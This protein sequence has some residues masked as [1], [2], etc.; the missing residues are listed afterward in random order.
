MQVGGALGPGAAHLITGMMQRGRGRGP[1]WARVGRTGRP[2][3]EGWPLECPGLQR[4]G[5]QHPQT[6]GL[7]AEPPPQGSPS[8]LPG[9]QPIRNSGADAF[10]VMELPSGM[11]PG[12]R[13]FPA[14][15][16]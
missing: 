8:R 7:E 15:S 3:Q 5:E 2:S 4:W 11:L 12:S 14:S 16:Q 10:S 1:C 13:V 9:S 6:P